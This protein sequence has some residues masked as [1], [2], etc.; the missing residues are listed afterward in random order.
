MSSRIIAWDLLKVMTIFLVIMGHF[1]LYMVNWPPFSCPIFGWIQSFHMPLFMAISGLFAVNGYVRDGWMRYCVKRFARLIVPC[2]SWL[3]IIFLVKG[4]MNDW[5]WSGPML[6][7]V[8]INDL[9]F[10]KSL[11]IC[12]ILGCLAYGNGRLKNRF[13]RIAL[14]LL[15]SQVCLIWN[16]FV[17]YPCFLC[18]ILIAK[19]LNALLHHVKFVLWISGSLFFVLSIYLAVSPDFWIVGTGIRQALFHGS[20]SIESSLGFLLDIVGRRYLVMFV[21]IMA[22]VFF[23]VGSYKLFLGI[24]AGFIMRRLVD[25]GKYT[26]GI[27]VIQTVIVENIFVSFIHADIYHSVVYVGVVFPLLSIVVIGVAACFNSLIASRFPIVAAVLFGE[28]Y[29]GLRFK[30]RI[31]NNL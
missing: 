26:L 5:T 24:K 13:V 25:V 19:Y 30:S 2:L 14:T 31:L 27:Y 7:G 12:S 3:G 18:G 22:S 10:L 15:I 20:L 23:I 21:G 4:M 16:V 28:K 9:W 11:F 17:M 1:L 6:K 29:R 8:L